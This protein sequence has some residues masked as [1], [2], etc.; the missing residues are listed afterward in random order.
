MPCITPRWHPTETMTALVWHGKRDVR[1]EIVPRPMITD[2]KDILLKVTSASL[3]GSDLHLYHNEVPE[4]QKG[5]I[6]GHEFMVLI[7]VISNHS[8]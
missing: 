2:P 1:L 4:M 3:C 5:D 6:L 7:R 8:D